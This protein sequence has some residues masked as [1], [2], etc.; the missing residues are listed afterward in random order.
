MNDY[1]CVLPFYSHEYSN[2]STAPVACCLLPLDTDIIELRNKMLLG[3]KSSSCR[4]C[5][6]LE[7]Q[8]KVSER[9]LKNQALDFYT[10]RDINLLEQDCKQGSFST[11]IV[12]L[13]TSSVCNSTCATCGPEASSA[14]SKLKG[15]PIKYDC[16]SDTV[17]KNINYSNIK[18]LSFVGGEPLYEQKNFTIL[19]QLIEEQ[20]TD[21]FISF[22]TN[23]S[24]PLTKNQISILEKFKNLNF[25]LS[26]DGVGKVF[27]YLRYPLSWDLLINNINLYRSMGINLS[28]SYTISNLNIFYY[29]ETINWFNEQNLKF[30]HNIVNYDKWFSPNSLPSTVK[31][32]LYAN[33]LLRSH[34][35]TDDDNFKKFISEIKYQ[36]QLKKISIRDY[37]PL[38][39]DLIDQNS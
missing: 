27:E 6:N 33:F 25:S 15:I 37:I 4:S 32:N 14:W 10:D 28:V 9:Q 1:F 13:Y 12:K 16:L 17:T 29:K 38:V 36:D 31:K 35:E 22:V 26:I 8:G 23:G 24:V 3:K 34:T 2:S 30:N 19:K 39:A 21:C 7:A 5:W 18:M 20:N 11:Q